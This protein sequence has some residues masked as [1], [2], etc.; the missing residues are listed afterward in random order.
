MD[1]D[2][3]L[4]AGKVILHH[5]LL[6]LTLNVSASPLDLTASHAWQA[7][8]ICAANSIKKPLIAGAGSSHKRRWRSATAGAC[9]KAGHSPSSPVCVLLFLCAVRQAV[10]PCGE[11]LSC[12]YHSDTTMSESM[13][14]YCVTPL[15]SGELLTSR[16]LNM[17]HMGLHSMA[18][19]GG[20]AGRYVVI[21][22]LCPTVQ[23]QDRAH[24]A[25]GSS[26]LST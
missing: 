2:P 11:K 6:A 14:D 5:T 3:E 20:C 15:T 23:R 17:A 10:L 12:T 4:S 18:H 21:D 24:K 19:R 16:C 22:L 25:A 1:Q 13:L 8:H 7:S 9:S 26:L